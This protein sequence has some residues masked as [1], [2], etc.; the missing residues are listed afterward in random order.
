MMAMVIMP[1][2]EGEELALGNG[3]LGKAGDMG[4]WEIESWA[5]QRAM[6]VK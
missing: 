1:E 4:C 2:F 5:R 6:E 3:K